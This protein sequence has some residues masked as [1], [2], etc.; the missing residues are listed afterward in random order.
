[1]TVI[2]EGKVNIDIPDGNVRKKD[3]VFYN[4]LMQLNR[5]MSI[6]ALK[7]FADMV[8]RDIV[9][10]DALASSGIRSLRMAKE[11][12]RIEKVYINDMNP[13][14][15]EISEKT[16]KDNDISNAE[17]S[18]SDANVF[19]S[20]HKNKFDYVDIDPFGSPVYFL[21]SCARAASGKSLIGISATDTAPLCGTYPKTCIRRYGSKPLREDIKHEIGLRILIGNIVRAFSRHNK[22]FV[23]VISYSKIHYFRIMGL[24]TSSTRLS[25]KSADT[26]GWALYCKKC[27]NRK[28]VKEV[29][30]STCEVC[31]DKF[32]SAGPLWIG[33]INS[34]LYL[35]KMIKKNDM[36]D[37]ALSSFI[38]LLKNESRSPNLFY[39]IHNVCKKN[40]LNIPKNEVLFEMLKNEGFMIEKSHFEHTGFKSDISYKQLL[41]LLKSFKK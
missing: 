6:L 30:L 34:H 11:C 8:K 26:V 12:A 1:M 13:T 18:I 4:P 5:D 38:E 24:S 39:D 19:L 22:S 25:G 35:E 16:A 7:V 14:A 37:K 27:G 23:P 20:M 21:D 9:V 41:K 15:I 31:G 2:T 3:A 28:L 40:Y 32:A 36:G 17:F 10:G 29:E 33:P